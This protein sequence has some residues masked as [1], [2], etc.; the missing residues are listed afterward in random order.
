MICL[1]ICSVFW[2]N[3]RITQSMIDREMLNELYSNMNDMYLS[4]KKVSSGKSVSKPSD[5]PSEIKTLMD[6]K[7]S[8]S[9]I[10][11]YQKNLNYL[12]NQLSKYD[13]QISLVYDEVSSVKQ[14]LLQTSISSSDIKKNLAEDIELS[15]KN[16]ISLLNYKDGSNFIFS[17]TKTSSKTFEYTMNLDPDGV[18]RIG[19]VSYNGN[20]EKRK[21]DIS[22]SENM[23]FSFNGKQISE[24]GGVDIF[25]ILINIKNALLNGQ[26]INSYQDNLDSYLNGLNDI[27]INLGSKISFVDKKLDLSSQEKLNL[28]ALISK[29]EDTDWG[30]EITNYQNIQN[31]HTTILNLIEKFRDERLTNYL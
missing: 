31:R 2:G 19:S 14:K 27:I 11:Q 3:M 25:N 18:Y 30:T 22:D 8:N 12:S 9:L 23:E 16:I 26:N 6:Y 24:N 20:D 15:L 1:T 28:T 29:I 17:G 10:D 5:N 21:I 13:S 7:L 4:S